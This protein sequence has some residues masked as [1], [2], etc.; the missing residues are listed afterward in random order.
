M[1]IQLITRRF[2]VSVHFPACDSGEYIHSPYPELPGH[3]YADYNVSV[4][5]HTKFA[6]QEYLCSLE[7][8]WEASWDNEGFQ[9]ALNVALRKPRDQY[10]LPHLVRQVWANERYKPVVEVKDI[11][12]YYA[13]GDLAIHCKVEVGGTSFTVNCPLNEVIAKVY[14]LYEA[15]GLPQLTEFNEAF[16]EFLSRV[17]AEE[18]KETTEQILSL[19]LHKVI[20]TV[21]P[22]S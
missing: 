4:V 16:L 10:G 12:P 1:E 19:G 17:S 14:A 18:D 6:L 5:L 13:G 7:N 8:D 22:F 2:N 20:V 9:V 21:R 15:T 11:R 3:C